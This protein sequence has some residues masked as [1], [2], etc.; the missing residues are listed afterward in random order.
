MDSQNQGYY[1]FSNADKLLPQ[2]EILETRRHKSSLTIGVPREISFQECRLP[3]VP[4]AVGLLVAN[5]HKVLIESDAGKAA[6]FED[7]E[8]SDNGA[9]IIHNKEEVFK[10]DII[11]KIAPPSIEEIELLR[12]K[13]TLFSSLHLSGQ[14]REY[15]ETLSIKKTTAIAYEFIKDKTGLFPILR[16][17]SEIAG[18]ASI[19]IAY[20]YLANKEYGA[21]KLFGGFPGI[22]PTEVVIIGA[23]T[24]AEY[25]A[26]V[27]LGSGALVKIF[28]NNIYKLRRI[29]DSLNARVFTSVIQPNILMKALKT[30]DVAIGALHSGEG[31]SSIIVTAEMVEQMK[32]GAVII[33]VSIDQG[34]CFET[35][36]ITNH[37]R[38]VFVKSGITHYCV[39]NIASKVPHTASY[40]LSNFFIP[41]LLKIGETGG[42][43][44]MIKSDF[45]LRKG[46]YL[47]NGTLTK[48][49]IGEYF[50]LPYQDIELL[51]AALR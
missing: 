34:G 23:G 14:S 20:E 19:F 48:S 42:I 27:A 21:G 15:F 18:T 25:A 5:G 6:N 28:D 9:R 7:L 16:A 43:E 37:N 2:E 24:V 38:P 40:A 13:Q 49:Y 8:Y 51:I 17:M 41:I 33:D 30:A 3:L 39:P 32:K 4:Q 22:P 29:Q 45:G 35:S 10:A 50:T 46:V 12:S 36:E 26:R 31:I 44:N 1:K 47:F 11:I